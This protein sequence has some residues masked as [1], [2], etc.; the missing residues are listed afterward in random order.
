[1]REL[2]AIS[3]RIEVKKTAEACVPLKPPEEEKEQKEKEEG[4]RDCLTLGLAAW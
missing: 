3:F 4:V 1:V 2:A